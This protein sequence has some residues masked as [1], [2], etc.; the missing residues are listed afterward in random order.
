M[1]KMNS[2][3]VG[4]LF[5]KPSVWLA[6]VVGLSICSVTLL[7]FHNEDWSS[8]GLAMIA[9]GLFGRMW[10]MGPME[11]RQKW[12]RRAL[13]L[14]AAFLFLPVVGH[15]LRSGPDGRPTT[16][17]GHIA[18]LVGALIKDVR[19]NLAEPPPL[20]GVIESKAEL[21]GTIRTDYLKLTNMTEKGIFPTACTLYSSSENQSLQLPEVIKPYDTVLVELK[22]QRGKIH[23]NNG[24]RIVIECKDYEKPLAIQGR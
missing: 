17:L 11:G 21:L 1:K 18:A 14:P 20:K 9:T 22:T 2:P 4:I 7:V 23:F 10:T 3:R 19:H 15:Q 8:F 13:L 16:G 5:E 6:L 12:F 24:D